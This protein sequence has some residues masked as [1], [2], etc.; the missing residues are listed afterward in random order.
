[1][2]A[3]Y[4]LLR[5]SEL[6]NWPRKIWLCGL[7]LMLVCCMLGGMRAAAKPIPDPYQVIRYEH[8]WKNSPFS[9]ATIVPDEGTNSTWVMTGISILDQSPFVSFTNMETRQSISLTPGESAKG[10]TLIHAEWASNSDDSFA[11]AEINGAQTKLQ[12]NTG[13]LNLLANKSAMTA[14]PLPVISSARPPLPQGR[15]ATPNITVNKS[16][17]NTSSG[18]AP[19]ARRRIIIRR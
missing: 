6:M 14:P 18:T 1:V 2:L 3:F 12:F 10:V 17:S 15:T 19:V 11:V 4:A 7:P 5:N 16:G 9:A 13:Q 8:L